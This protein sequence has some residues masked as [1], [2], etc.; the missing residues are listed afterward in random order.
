MNDDLTLL[1]EFAASHSETAF[2][3]LVTRHVNLV[4]SVALR[5]V[6]D[7]HLAEEVSQAVFI[8]LARKAGALGDKTILPGWLCRT[9][10]YTAADVLKNRH[11]RQQREQEAHMQSTVN[12]PE[13][14][15]W[16][17][18]TPLLEPAMAQLGQKDHDA[19]VLRF[20]ENK[21]FAEVGAALGA[22]EDAAKMRVNRALEKLR[23]L[24]AKQGLT[25]GATALAGAV[26]ANAGQAAPAALAATISAA[27]L[28][29]TTLTLATVAMTT[30]Q[31]IAVTAAL[32]VTIGVGI[33]AAKQA[34]DAQNQLQK[35]QAQ[36][37][38]L[39]EQNHQLQAERDQ[40]T[41]ALA[42]LNEK[43]AK[44]QTNNLELLKL[45]GEVGLLRNKADALRKEPNA[46]N[47]SPASN[48]NPAAVFQIHLKAWFLSLPA[49]NLA[50]LQNV[51][52]SPIPGDAGLSGIVSWEKCTNL[53][54]LVKGRAGAET[55][56]EPE[57]T[58]PSGRQLQ[59]RATQ[60]VSV[61]TNLA[62]L[63]TNGSV[64]LVPE[65]DKV[66]TGPIFEATPRILPDGS[67]IELPVTASVID[68]LGYAATSNTVPAYTKNGEPVAVPAVSPQYRVQQHSSK[69]NLFDGQ[70]LV[71]KLD[72]KLAASNAPL[73]NPSGEKVDVQN[74]DR[75]V[76]V[77]A[78]IID[79]AGNRISKLSAGD[80]I[81][82][83]PPL[84]S[85]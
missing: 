12:E 29:G 26:A 20:F 65:L 27:A 61:V 19:L 36:Q 15:I 35:L 14:E 10:R 80:G 11:R 33:Y 48:T 9:T 31:K 73:V 83:Q 81:P 21:N 49:G 52:G 2:A 70:T 44:N 17:Q 60:I 63:E 50:T 30:F 4:Y 45:R 32:T 38:P 74:Y 23:H 76:F 7:P 39:V 18:I 41:N 67:T 58:S 68:F 56:G 37:A 66:E 55:L 71:L 72:D 43:L 84:T 77:T 22:S 34:Y 78:T 24:L 16:P 46:S 5:Q 54:A 53:L 85:N 6:R 42:L 13:S 47:D 75:L 51:I 1:R 82:D 25:L 8:I 3:A 28:T 40:A 79:A 59:M 62:L 64:S 57:V 69:V